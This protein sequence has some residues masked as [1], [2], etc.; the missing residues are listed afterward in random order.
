MPPHR[1]LF[2][3]LFLA[4]CS[5]GTVAPTPAMHRPI[6]SMMVRPGVTVR[7]IVG[8]VGSSDSVTAIND[9]DMVV[10]M[11][12]L[13]SKSSAFRWTSGTGVQFLQ[14]PT[15]WHSEA[16]ALND[17]GTVVGDVSSA[18][19]Q[20]PARWVNGGGLQEMSLLFPGD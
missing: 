4:A 1:V 9:S 10:G 11:R 5:E 8:L 16:F 18:P 15:G 13:G 14:T 17:S 19:Q 2:S 12:V 6:S 7:K 3:M 20:L